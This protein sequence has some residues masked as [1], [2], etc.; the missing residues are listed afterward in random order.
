MPRVIAPKG[1]LSK[2]LL[3]PGLPLRLL[4][5]PFFVLTVLAFRCPFEPLVDSSEHGLPTAFAGHLYLA[6][7]CG[8]CPSW[9]YV[10]PREEKVLTLL[11][12]ELR[13]GNHR[14][15]FVWH[16]VSLPVIRSGALA[17]PFVVCREKASAAGSYWCRFPI[18]FLALPSWECCLPLRVP[19]GPV[20]LFGGAFSFR[21]T[22]P[23]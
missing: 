1:A 23:S 20:N 12:P 21:H 3:L 16:L 13:V 11:V 4:L 17:C 8:R 10:S 14:L 15:L 22:H 18:Y 5:H 9:V 19:A 2:V 6:L 7:G